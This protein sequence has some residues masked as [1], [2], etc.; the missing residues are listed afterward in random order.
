MISTPN[1]GVCVL[2]NVSQE[3]TMINCTELLHSITSDTD[4]E[5]M[6]VQ[7]KTKEATEKD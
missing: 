7:T 1:K 2:R 3:I 5:K 4:A 6:L